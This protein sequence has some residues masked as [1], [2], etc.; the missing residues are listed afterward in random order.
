MARTPFKRTARVSSLIRQVLGE[1]LTFEIK[2]PRV[3]GASVTEV[4]VTGDL[5]EARIY[6]IHPGDDAEAKSL[7]RGLEAASGY[8]RR[9]LGQRVRLRVTPSLEF[10]FDRSIEYGARIESKLRELGLGGEGEAGEG[11]EGA[12]GDDP[13]SGDDFDD[14]GSGDDLGSS[15]DLDSSDDFDSVDDSQDG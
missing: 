10:R 5:R 9:E 7:M 11:E 14:S 13:D 2:D 3:Q 8:L 1:L 4:E 15:D 6:L 12:S